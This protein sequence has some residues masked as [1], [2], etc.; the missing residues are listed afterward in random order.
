[1]SQALQTPQ[2]PSVMVINTTHTKPHEVLLAPTTLRTLT[3]TIILMN[4]NTTVSS[5]TASDVITVNSSHPSV[6]RISCSLLHYVTTLCALALQFTLYCSLA[7]TVVNTSIF[8]A[9]MCCF[10]ASNSALS[11][12][13]RAYTICFYLKHCT[14]LTTRSV[15]TY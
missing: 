3:S 11:L 7:N 5:G 4:C 2:E 14:S 9:S 10:T 6:T 15:L 8:P 12:P 13:S 1:M